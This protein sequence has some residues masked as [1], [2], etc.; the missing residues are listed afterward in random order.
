MRDYRNHNARR[1]ALRGRRSRV[2]MLLGWV[3][4]VGCSEMDAAFEGSMDDRDDP[5]AYIDRVTPGRIDADSLDGGA[6][7]GECDGGRFQLD[8]RCVGPV[9]EDREAVCGF[10][11]SLEADCTDFDGD[12]FV[13]RCA[14]EL[15]APLLDAIFDC[16][17]AR[18]T[19]NPQA[20]E[21]CDELDNDCNGLEDEGFAIGEACETGCGAGKTECSVADPQTVACSTA[22]GQSGH[23]PSEEICNGVDDD[24]DGVVDDRCRLQLDAEI[25]PT[26]PALCG[27]AIVFVDAGTGR[28]FRLARANDAGETDNPWSAS[29][30]E[31]LAARR[32]AWP[33]CN[34]QVLAWLEIQEEEESCTTPDDGPMRCQARLML[35]DGVDVE[36]AQDLTGQDLLGPPVVR[37]DDLLWHAISNGRPILRRLRLAGPTEDRD[38]ADD[39]SDPAVGSNGVVAARRWTNGRAEIAVLQDD[40]RTYF[41]SPDVNPGPPA[42]GDGWIVWSVGSPPALWVVNLAEPSSGFQLTDGNGAQRTPRLAGSRLVWLDAGTQPPTLREIDL[43]TGVG[44]TLVQAGVGENNFAVRDTTAVWVVTTDER[45]SL[46]WHAP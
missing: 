41:D 21:I 16:D 4:L 40:S 5:G 23:A 27:D 24:C 42:L 11:E 2:W 46:Y 44:Q 17:D 34:E 38:L 14:V 9:P 30:T 36:S 32:A 20:D 1:A 15:P 7:S 35:H 6:P 3:G 19:V 28:L 18:P 12:C 25:M 39:L 22:A 37:R 26:M 33:A 43:A 10:V 31:I 29:P 13:E 45:A 8:E